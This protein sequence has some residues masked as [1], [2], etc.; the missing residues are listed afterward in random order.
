MR[1]AIA[2]LALFLA[3]TVAQARNIDLVTLP[4]RAK[5]QLTI[6]NSED[7]TL[8]KEARAIAFKK[9]VNRLEFSWANTLIDPTSVYFRALEHENEIDVADTTFPADRPQVLVWNVE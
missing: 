6:Y 4:P 1:Y 9:G 5:V 7:L 3:A 8:V 2:I